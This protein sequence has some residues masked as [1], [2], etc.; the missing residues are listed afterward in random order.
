MSDNMVYLNILNASLK[1]SCLFIIL[2]SLGGCYGRFW[3]QY[4]IHFPENKEGLHWV[5]DDYIYFSYQLCLQFNVPK[6]VYLCEVHEWKHT[7]PGESKISYFFNTPT[8]ILSLA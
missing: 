1:R 5:S 6:T 8:C 3:W 2:V 4:S 7:I